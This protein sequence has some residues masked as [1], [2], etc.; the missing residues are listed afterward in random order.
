MARFARR[1]KRRSLSVV[2][3]QKVILT[4]A[5]ASRTGGTI[6]PFGLS[7]GKDGIPAGQASGT[8]ETVPTGSVIK[9]ME[10]QYC[11]SNLTN[12]ACF[13]SVSIQRIHTG[14]SH[15][16]PRSVGGDAQRNQVFFQKIFNIG[17]NQNS[18]H[19]F[20][21]KIP[22]KYQRVREGDKWQFVTVNDSNIDDNLQVIYKYYR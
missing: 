9:F 1:F 16:D 22:K 5:P 3:S 20:R 15:I 8:D 2:Q 6:V 7:E 19:V 4:Y 21:F 13:S 14:Q 18:N 10:I 17:D 12:Q 11:V